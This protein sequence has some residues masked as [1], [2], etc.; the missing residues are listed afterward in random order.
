MILYFFNFGILKYLMYYLFFN[1]LKPRFLFIFHNPFAQVRASH[2]HL[3][4]WWTRGPRPIFPRGWCLHLWKISIYI[5]IKIKIYLMFFYITSPGKPIITHRSLSIFPKIPIFSSLV[6]S[7]S[8]IWVYFLNE[9][10]FYFNL[11]INF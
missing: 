7:I 2:V 5:T 1:T 11:N 9:H 3:L 10:Y 6:S 4:T 8:Q